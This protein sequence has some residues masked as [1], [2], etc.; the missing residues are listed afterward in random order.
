MSIEH[1]NRNV[2]YRQLQL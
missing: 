1:I 2:A